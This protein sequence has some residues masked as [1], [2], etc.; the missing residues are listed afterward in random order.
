MNSRKF[1]TVAAVTLILLAHGAGLAGNC[2]FCLSVDA[3]APCAQAQTPEA[4]PTLAPSCCCGEI[5]CGQLAAEIDVPEVPLANVSPFALLPGSYSQLAT[6]QLSRP[7]SVNV[8]A[9][10]LPIQPLYK[11]THS[12]LL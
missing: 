3:V 12:Y 2:S 8:V 4:N 1:T 10:S 6:A 5:S 11:L 9:V 7:V